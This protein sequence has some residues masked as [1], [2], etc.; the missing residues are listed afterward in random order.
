MHSDLKL[1]F[2]GVW[3]TGCIG[4]QLNRDELRKKDVIPR[5][6]KIFEPRERTSARRQAGSMA[7]ILYR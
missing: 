5:E 3:A 6:I 1:S 4:S 7:G 2:D